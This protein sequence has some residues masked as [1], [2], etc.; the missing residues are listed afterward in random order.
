MVDGGGDGNSNSNGTHYASGLVGIA[1]GTAIGARHPLLG[2]AY[3]IANLQGNYSNNN[4][5]GTGT[6]QSYGGYGRDTGGGMMQAGGS[7]GGYGR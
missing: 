4:G 7:R 1:I 5:V 2:I 3:S 6:N